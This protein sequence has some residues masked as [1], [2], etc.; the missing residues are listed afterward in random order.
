MNDQADNLRKA[1]GQFR[2]VTLSSLE[3]EPAPESARRPAR[4]FTVTSGKG[5][6]GKT[7]VSINLAIALSEMGHKV[8]I[9]DADFGLANVEVLF[10]II[11]KYKLADAIHN[12][13]SVREIICDGPRGVKFISG[14]SG[15]DEIIRMDG[16]QIGTLIAGLSDVDGDFDVIIID[17]GAGL[18]ETVLGMALAA[19][20]VVLVTTP[21]PTA[22]TDAY[23]LIK[24]LAQRDRDKP[25]RLIVNRADNPAEAA[26][27]MNKLTLVSDRFLD[28]KLRKLGY[29]LND[30]LVV[31]SVKQQQPF[32]ISFPR[33]PLARSIREIAQRLMEREAFSET[34]AGRGLS[35]FLSGMTRLLNMQ[36][37]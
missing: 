35:G 4:V 30:P 33:S 31:R 8:A 17:T 3:A 18:S 25:I 7:N 16:E 24:T 12:D 19:D 15:I 36:Y 32:I 34:G 1:I 23:A 10:G 28:L 11:P 29:I 37:K 21:E 14:G 6:V 9:I 2:D 5:G 27:I 22:V 13:K 26:D 20:E